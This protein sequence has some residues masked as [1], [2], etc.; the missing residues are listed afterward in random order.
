MLIYFCKRETF[1]WLFTIPWSIDAAVSIFAW[2]LFYFLAHCLHYVGSWG[3]VVCVGSAQFKVAEVPCRWLGTY[4]SFKGL[5][6]GAKKPQLADKNLFWISVNT[7]E[8]LER[9]SRWVG[10]G[11]CSA[12]WLEYLCWYIGMENWV[13]AVKTLLANGL[14]MSKIDFVKPKQK[15]KKRKRI[16]MYVGGHRRL[17]EAGDAMLSSP[18]RRRPRL[19]QTKRSMKE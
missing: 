1:T 3:A 17:E 2:V 5:Y 7:K 13:I 18:R 16:T 4:G 12:R 19:C 14:N 6:K 10:S 8:K 15:K 11:R 9:R